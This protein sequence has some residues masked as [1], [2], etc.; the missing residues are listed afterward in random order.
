M[1]RLAIIPVLS[2]LLTAASAQSSWH[3]RYAP[4]DPALVN[5][6]LLTQRWSAGWVS[7]PET[8][9][10]EYGVYHFRRT[11]TLDSAPASFVVH[12]TADN[13]Y[14]L[15]VNGRRVAWG[16][17][18]G[19]LA[20]WR[21][22]SLDLAPHL[23]AGKNVVA[24]VVWNFGQYAA[25][26]QVTNQ[27]GFLLQGNTEKERVVETGGQWK[28][29]H[30]EAFRPLHYTHAQMRGYFVVGPG[31]HVDGT[32][33]P[34]GW[35]TIDFDD[36][37]W[38]AAKVDSRGA[39]SPWG[40][41]DAGNRWMLVPR[42]IPMMEEKP[43]R[44]AATRLSNGIDV[45]AGF[46]AQTG[47]L[48]IPANSEVR[49]ILD[50]SYLTTAYPE[51]VISGGK[52]GQ[53]RIGYAESLFDR[54]A[55]RGDKG[56]R[57]EVEGKEFIGFYDEFIPD[58]YA[59]R[60]FRPLWWRTY[61]YLELKVRTGS[62]PLT[63]EDL[64][65]VHVSYPF[66]MKARLETG[67][68]RIEKLM[69]VG[70]R[71][72]RLCAHES[73]M[74]CPYY[75]QLQYAG[76]TRI[77]GLISLYNSGDSRLLRNAIAQLDDS[78]S[79]EG[80]TLSRAPTRQEQYIPPFSLWWIGMLHDYWMYEDDPQFVR[81]TLPGVRTVLSFYHGFQKTDGSLRRMPFWNFVDWAGAWPNGVPPVEEDGSSA[82]LDLQLY[83][84]YQWAARMEKALG[85]EGG[86]REYTARAA[87]LGETIKKIYWN[88]GRRMFS[89]TPSGEHW[90][91]FANALAVLSGLVEGEEARSLIDRV[92]A[93]QTIVPCTY[94][95]KYYLNSAVN[96]V[97]EGDRYL[98]LLG[99]WDE[100]L[101]S[102]LTTWAER[103]VGASNPPRSDCH[104]WSAHPNFELFRT[105]LGI[106][107]LAPGFARVQVRPFLGKL[108]R[109]SGM[110]P[111]PKGEI[112]VTLERTGGQLTAEVSLPDGITGEFLWMGARRSLSGGTNRLVFLGP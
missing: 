54:G 51:L 87:Q 26:A 92:L 46:P 36:S 79:P 5:P 14:E 45:P 21:Y 17:A 18:R 20:H 42:S 59:R 99:E 77:Q 61:R 101:A 103:P 106:D 57:N 67:S 6:Q 112:A 95:S 108:N 2:F 97:G 22:E 96:L 86:A 32:I 35:E 84:A 16:P 85:S 64:R 93:D 12:V 72:A 52:G 53:V 30:N 78:R 68:E 9:P 31:D 94:Y 49:L 23:R 27:T 39:G 69:E 44:L 81:Q 91:Q 98:D 66:E 75:E 33:F 37:G 74:D 62:E 89:D 88:P 28:C 56:N 7:V 47:E 55:R 73:Y 107:S 43:E 80:L 11:F 34:W 29:L 111:H 40:T 100:M 65:G 24:A 60:L 83:L 71:T 1:T 104:A 15:F 110:I 105:L 63:I 10:F 58:G 76:D 38:P 8:S 25:E 4:L 82:L 48:R 102:G 41:R 90:S 109:V 3:S 50:Q 13:R 19:D 70:W